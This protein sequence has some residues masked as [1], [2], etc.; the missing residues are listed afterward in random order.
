MH[1]SI[2]AFFLRWNNDSSRLDWLLC[3]L[4]CS[5]LNVSWSQK[6]LAKEGKRTEWQAQ[7]FTGGTAKRLKLHFRSKITVLFPWIVTVCYCDQVK[8]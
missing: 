6:P 7:S 3:F 1:L 2:V 5:A 8:T 4:L